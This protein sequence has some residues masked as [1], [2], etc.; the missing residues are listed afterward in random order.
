MFVDLFR[1]FHG[2]ANVH[3][4]GV[5]SVVSSVAGLYV[6]LN[7]RLLTALLPL[8]LQP[9]QTQTCGAKLE[10]PEES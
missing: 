2:E 9:S 10:N 3:Q 1:K 8:F 5:D 7:T 4:E 6:P